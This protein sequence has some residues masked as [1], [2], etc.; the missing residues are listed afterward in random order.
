MDFKSEK[1]WMLNTTSCCVV[2]GF[3]L[4]KGTHIALAKLQPNPA[5]VRF[6]CRVPVITMSRLRLGVVRSEV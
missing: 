1:E 4:D 5:E 2:C 3:P 6:E